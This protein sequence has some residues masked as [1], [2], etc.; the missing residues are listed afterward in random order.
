MSKIRL[1]N[2]AIILLTALYRHHLNQQSFFVRLKQRFS[3]ATPVLDITNL[4]LAQRK[5]ACQ[6]LA[7]LGFIT[8]QTEHHLYGEVTL[9]EKGLEYASLL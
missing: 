7:S 4:S 6:E 1:S 3:K 2:E 8:L 9:T 5:S